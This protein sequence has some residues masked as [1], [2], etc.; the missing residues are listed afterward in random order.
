[1]AGNARNPFENFVFIQG[2]L[3]RDPEMRYTATG[4]ALVTFAI[5]NSEYFKKDGVRKEQTGFY[6]VKAWG[7]LAEYLSDKIRKGDDVQV[8]G[9][10]NQESWEDKNTGAKR[11]KITIV[12]NRVA[13][14]TWPDN[15]DGSGARQESGAESGAAAGGDD[16]V[17]EDDIP[18]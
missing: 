2:R 18:F 10:L 13:M 14:M 9:K 17:S 7:K 4:T 5:A 1:M 15:G 16:Y 11:S 12:A 8:V 3:T 6:D